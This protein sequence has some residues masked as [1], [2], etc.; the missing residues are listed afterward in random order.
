MVS[1]QHHGKEAVIYL[2]VFSLLLGQVDTWGGLFPMPV[3]LFHFSCTLLL[4]SMFILWEENT[5]PGQRQSGARNSMLVL[6][7]SLAVW[8]YQRVYI[9]KHSGTN[10]GG[11]AR[12]LLLLTSLVPTLIIVLSVV[13]SATSLI[14]LR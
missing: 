3:F 2:V 6:L 12:D 1:I 13:S 14:F 9:G 5:G 10:S 11:C 8:F 7:V 4:L